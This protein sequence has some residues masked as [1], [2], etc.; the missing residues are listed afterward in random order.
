[1]V[2]HE[3]LEGIDGL[4]LAI[5]HPDNAVTSAKDPELVSGQNTALIL[6]KA[7]NGVIEDVASDVSVDGAERIVHEYDV[8]IEVNS[9]GNVKTLL[10]TTRDGNTT[11]TNLR[12]ITV[13]EHI[14]I[15]LKGATKKRR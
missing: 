14:N 11:F 13:R 5:L 2:L 4:N 12:H 6:E 1:M 3:F 10:L 7:K 8:G 9:S 15:R